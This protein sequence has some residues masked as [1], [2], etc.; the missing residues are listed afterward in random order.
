MVKKTVLFKSEERKDL[1]DIAAFLRQLADKIEAGVIVLQRGEEEIRLE[2]PASV[3]FEI[4]ADEKPKQL[5]KQQSL[6]IEL[7]WIEGES[8]E[9][10]T[11]G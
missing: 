8:G 3:E 1:K 2:L 7:E 4:Q 11:L 5:G 9:T 6:E 10:V